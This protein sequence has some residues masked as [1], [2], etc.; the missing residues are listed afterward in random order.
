MQFFLSKSVVEI[1]ITH[2]YNVKIAKIIY[3]DLS[4][5]IL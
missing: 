3:Y 1:Q 2:F 4:D 5:I